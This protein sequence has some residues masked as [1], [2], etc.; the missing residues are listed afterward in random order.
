MYLDIRIKKPIISS[1]F[2]YEYFFVIFIDFLT[3]SYLITQVFWPNKLILE[4][5]IAIT[6]N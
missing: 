5:K 6:L 4:V 2:I 3:K 1:Y